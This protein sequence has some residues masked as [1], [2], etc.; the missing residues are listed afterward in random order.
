MLYLLISTKARL[1]IFAPRKARSSFSVLSATV[2]NLPAG[3]NRWG[4]GAERLKNSAGGG[5]SLGGGEGLAVVPGHPVGRLGRE[6]IGVA[7][8]F[9]EVVEG[10][11]AAEG[12]GVDQTHE[13][14]AHLGPVLGLEEEG[15]ST[16]PDRHFQR[17]FADIIVQRSSRYPQKQRQLLPVLEHV[18]DG[19]AERRIR[20][21]EP[22]VELPRQPGVKVLHRRTAL[23][24]MEGQPI[25]GRQFP[26]AG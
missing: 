3:R 5:H 12:A 22:V 17:P 8:E 11:G 19:A 6:L 4:R 15:I 9:G 20:L 16:M 10:V 18:R 25:L 23:G 26:L 7:V 14:V 2:K 21:D 13:E 24:L 1:R